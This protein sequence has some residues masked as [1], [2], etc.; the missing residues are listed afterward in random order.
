MPDKII[1]LRS[2]TAGSVP[3]TS[4]LGVGQIAINVNDGKIFVRQSGSYGDTVQT[5]VTTNNVTTGSVTISGSLFVSGAL[6]IFGAITANSFT[7]S[8]F[9]TSSWA[10]NTTYATSA[11]QII[12]NG[13][14]TTVSTDP[15]QLFVIKSGTTKYINISSSGNT[16]IYS[17]LFT[18]RN[19][20][21]KEPVLTVTQSIVKIAT[22]SVDPNIPA[23]NGGIWFTSASLF[24]GLDS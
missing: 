16:D 6:G 3:S 15:S 10:N 17:D 14:V 21:T 12:S 8:V 18:I 7:G 20:T 2:L 1:H 19:F 4:S 5:A 11:S 24:V 22:Q 13:V 23:I 9:G